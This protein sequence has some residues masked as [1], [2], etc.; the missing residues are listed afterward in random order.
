MKR[1]W[2]L[3]KFWRSARLMQHRLAA[4]GRVFFALA[5]VAFGAQLIAHGRFLAG[6]FPAQPWTPALDRTG[7][8]LF[9]F[10][11]VSFG[12]QYF[13]YADYL[14]T[15]VPGWL[16]AHL[17]FVH[18]TGMGFVAAGIAIGTNVLA[19]LGAECLGLMFFLWLVVL[20]G[21]RVAAAP[22]NYAEFASFVVALAMCGSGW[23]LTGARS[24]QG[25]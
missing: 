7:R 14:A 18:V 8:L 21:P 5:V 12:I 2:S 17:A 13:Q 16:P 24:S 4:I 9:A 22:A 25:R 19:R 20:H 15:L 23:I 1:F 3:W 10:S 6:L 11:L